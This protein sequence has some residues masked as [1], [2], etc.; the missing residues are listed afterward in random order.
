MRYLSKTLVSLA[1]ATGPVQRASRQGTILCSTGKGDPQAG[2]R[3][4]IKP[5]QQAAPLLIDLGC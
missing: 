4:Q 3:P 5:E 1:P 2:K